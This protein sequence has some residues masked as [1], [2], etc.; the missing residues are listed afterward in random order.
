MTGKPSDFGLRNVF[1][2]PLRDSNKMGK[3]DDKC[4]FWEGLKNS[5]FKMAKKT[6]FF[7][8]KIWVLR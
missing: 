8:D 1:L 5:I 6:I 7:G 3:T 4:I 2:T